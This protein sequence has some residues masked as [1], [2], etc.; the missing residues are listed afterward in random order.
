MSLNKRHVRYRGGTEVGYLSERDSDV[1]ISQVNLFN[2]HCA[3]GELV[4]LS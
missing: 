4:S 1:G 2:D 3:Y